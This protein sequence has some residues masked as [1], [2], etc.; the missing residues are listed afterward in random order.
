MNGVFGRSVDVNV[1]VYSEPKYTTIRWYKNTT[2]LKQSTKYSMTENMMIVYDDF[3]GKEVQLDGYKLNLVIK[4]LR[5]E[6]AAV[7]KLQLSNGI[8]HLVEHNLILEIGHIPQTPTNI[9]VVSVGGS[10]LTIQWVH[11]DDR[12]LHLVYHIA[13]KLSISSTWIRKEMITKETGNKE[14]LYTLAGLQTSTYYDVR[15]LAENSFNKSLPSTVITAQTLSKENTPNAIQSASIP[16]VA[17]GTSS[18]I[19]TIVAWLI[20]G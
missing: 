8:G 16:I 9:T 2:L 17:L 14:L 5:F 6:D 7:Y 15:I 13:Y 4:E 3:H 12:E 18:T 10:S 11:V 19:I 1:Y 20:V